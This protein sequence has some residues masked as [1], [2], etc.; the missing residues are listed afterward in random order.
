MPDTYISAR[1]S[2]LLDRWYLEMRPA[3]QAL[4]TAELS[5]LATFE[6][7]FKKAIWSD[8]TKDIADDASQ[9]AGLT[10]DT[11]SK[12]HGRIL[13]EADD[14]KIS[15]DLLS[16]DTSELDAEH[17]KWKARAESRASA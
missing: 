9:S 14:F 16:F 6:E 8:E 5:K 11:L 12:L 13:T 2:D 7:V 4:R 1:G 15:P 10:L 17:S 3:L